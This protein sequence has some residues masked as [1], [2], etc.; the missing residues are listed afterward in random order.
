MDGLQFD[1]L[2]R[3][4]T[5]SRRSLL[6]G[7]LAGVTGLSSLNGADAK[8]KGGK[9]K[10]KGGR[11][12]KKGK[13]RPTAC[14]A[15]TCNGCCE[16]PEGDCLQGDDHDVCGKSGETCHACD[17]LGI[18]DN[19]ECCIPL[20]GA[21]QYGKCCKFPKTEC[22]DGYCCVGVYR[23]CEQP[24][25]FCC[26]GTSCVAE[27]G[28]LSRVCCPDS[29]VCGSTCCEPG[30]SCLDPTTE[31]CGFTCSNNGGTCLIDANCCEDEDRCDGGTCKRRHREFC[32]AGIICEDAHPI[33]A[34]NRCLR[35]ALP[36]IET[37]T[38][39]VC[40]HPSYSCDAANGGVGACCVN[41]FCCL[42]HE[43]GLCM[44]TEH[45]TDSC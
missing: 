39:E 15:S 35:C 2:L 33:C 41:E 29:Q 19:N 42:P 3:S 31:N 13:K 17:T 36:Q 14:N 37:G 26:A 11:K 1:D 4:L 16:S 22:S 7:M 9:G 5:E 44:E 28:S 18:C 34:Q 43:S 8:K 23:P 21:C 40:C 20:G 27:Q 12:G 32:E 45:G 25:P 30:L 10:G 24:N 6:A 38:S